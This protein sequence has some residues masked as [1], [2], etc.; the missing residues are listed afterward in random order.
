MLPLI[1]LPAIL[2]TRALA[3]TFTPLA[4]LPDAI[5]SGR[6]APVAK[7]VDVILPSA[8][9]DSAVIVPFILLESIVALVNFPLIVEAGIKTLSR[10]P[11]DILAA[12]IFPVTN[13]LFIVSCNLLTS[14]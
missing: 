12:L 10:N 4:K 11:P 8:R 14:I 13:V 9:I 5:F 3:F 6:T 2:P 7:C 1:E